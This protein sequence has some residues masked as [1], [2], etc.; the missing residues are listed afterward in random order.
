MC[1][2]LCG[3]QNGVNVKNPQTP[4]HLF[5]FTPF[6]NTCN[7]PEVGCLM[8]CEMFRKAVITHPVETEVIG[9]LFALHYSLSVQM[10][11]GDL[12]KGDFVQFKLNGSGLMQKKSKWPHNVTLTVRWTRLKYLNS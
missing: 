9:H 3:V 1:L 4:L 6:F 11:I 8:S 10:I 12:K 7:T 5:T 2:F